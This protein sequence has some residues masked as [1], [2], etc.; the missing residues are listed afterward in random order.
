MKKLVYGII[1]FAFLFSVTVMAQD[2]PKKQKAETKKECA[3]SCD[4][5]A[6]AKKDCKTAK[7]ECNGEAKKDCDTKKASKK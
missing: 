3:K 7:A 5:K 6:E 2:I 4:K 1:A